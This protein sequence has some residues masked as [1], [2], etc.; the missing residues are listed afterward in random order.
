MIWFATGTCGPRTRVPPS[1]P[2][3]RTFF[4]EGGT[5]QRGVPLAFHSR[6]PFSWAAG[7]ARSK[8]QGEGFAASGRAALMRLWVSHCLLVSAGFGI[9]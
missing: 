4:A 9:V 6:Y 8:A 1:R 3:S 2:L 5:T 7:D